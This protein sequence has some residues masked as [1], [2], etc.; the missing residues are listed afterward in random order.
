ME[1][2]L[3]IIEV[4]LA[5]DHVHRGHRI[6]VR[7]CVDIIIIINTTVHIRVHIA[8]IEK[9]NMNDNISKAVY[10]VRA[11]LVVHLGC[12][13]KETG[14]AITVR[15]STSNGERCVISVSIPKEKTKA[16][17]ID[18]VKEAVLT[19]ASQEAVVVG[20]VSL[21]RIQVKVDMLGIIGMIVITSAQAG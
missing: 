7:L 14:N 17:T 12:S 18:A 9:E 11:T 16:R 20:I 13:R 8:M 15:T 5:R 6:R 3:T 4:S 2:I 10:N 1:D 19:M 21:C